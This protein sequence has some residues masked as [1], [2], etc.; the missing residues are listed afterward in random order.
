[1][2]LKMEVYSP[3]LEL[4]GILEV[5]DALIYEEY[6]FRPGTFSLK[7]TLNEQTKPLLQPENILWLEG[8]TAGVIEYLE[9]TTEEDGIMLSVKGSLLSGILKRRVLWGT[10]QLH[11]GI[12]ELMYHLVSDCA[13]APTRGQADKRIIP[14]LTLR[15]TPP[16]DARIYWKQSTGEELA[17]TLTELAQAGQVAYGVAFDAQAQ[18][19]EFWARMGVNR[20]IGQENPVFYS[21]ELDDVLRAVYAYDAGDYRNLML[22]A[23]EG[24]GDA[25]RLLAVSES[26]D[27]PNEP[28]GLFRREAFV[29]A[30]DLKSTGKGAAAPPITEAEYLALL[31]TR[32]LEK[33][34]DWQLVQSFS[35]T[36]RTVAPT[37]TYGV[38]FFLGDTITVIDERL[39]LMVDAVVEGVERSVGKKSEDLVLTFGYGMPTLSD[40][41][42]RAG[43]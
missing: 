2:E 33:L 8:E 26:A 1:M 7:S 28:A 23:G 10:Y 20:T 32:G 35:A 39:G 14:R 37:Y 29:D 6:A 18:R 19:M 11:G 30:G 38:D 40:R 24:E 21:T 22:V 9:K 12:P 42:R 41:L 16:A 5:Y 13:V 43:V 27:A 34:A 4:L 3:A 17:K 15:G 31:R 36:V 25:R